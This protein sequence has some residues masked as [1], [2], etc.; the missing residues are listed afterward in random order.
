[1]LNELRAITSRKAGPKR[2]GQCPV[3]HPELSV[4][5]LLGLLNFGLLVS[6]LYRRM[7]RIDTTT[8]SRNQ[9][10][11][12]QG[13][14]Q[15]TSHPRDGRALAFTALAWV[16]T[17]S[18]VLAIVMLVMAAGGVEFA[19]PMVWGATGFVIIC[20]FATVQALLSEQARLSPGFDVEQLLK[21]IKDSAGF[22]SENDKALL[23]RAL[24]ESWISRS[25]AQRAGYALLLVTLSLVWA[26]AVGYGAVLFAK[27]LSFQPLSAVSIT[28]LTALLLIGATALP[29]SLLA[30]VARSQEDE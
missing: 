8:P 16:A 30:L 4:A 13:P 3:T 12:S 28:I 17:L 14:A 15:N 22:E 2:S 7:M 25:R 21:K 29:V 10:M 9:R 18:V 6:P 20:S 26:G 5:L 24:Q 1:M 19:L 27:S 23:V 11:N